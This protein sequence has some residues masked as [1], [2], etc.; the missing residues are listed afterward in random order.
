[1]PPADLA[2]VHR[3]LC[4]LR[5]FVAEELAGVRQSLGAVQTDVQYLRSAGGRR[6]DP[7]VC[8]L[9]PLAWRE[10]GGLIWTAGEVI[11]L[12]ELRPEW[13]AA[14]AALPGD[15]AKRLGRALSRNKDR[16]HAGLRL[17]IDRPE[18]SPLEFRV[19]STGQKL[20]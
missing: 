2:D 13:A 3:E 9:L 7:A 17:V 12:A 20:P 18:K 15:K 19:V 14:L 16:E 10:W 6:P 4:A 5:R 1:M 8:A 11:A